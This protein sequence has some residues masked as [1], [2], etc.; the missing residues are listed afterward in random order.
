MESVSSRTSRTKKSSN[1]RLSALEKLQKLKSEGR[2]YKAE[3]KDIDNVYE[4]VD[5]SKYSEII[6]GR[7]ED[8]WIV[9]DGSGAYRD[10]GREIFEMEDEDMEENYENKKRKKTEINIVEK[11]KYGANIKQMFK[12]STKKGKNEIQDVKLQKDDI[13]QD[14]IKELDQTLM[15]PSHMKPASNNNF[16]YIPNREKSLRHNDNFYEFHMDSVDDGYDPYDE[17]QDQ[18]KRDGQIP[19]KSSVDKNDG[20]LDVNQDCKYLSHAKQKN[21]IAV[22]NHQVSQR[23]QDPPHHDPQEENSVS[24]FSEDFSND[25]W[26]VNNKQEGTHADT[27]PLQLND[28]RNISSTSVIKQGKNSG[29]I[30][31][32]NET[33]PEIGQLSNHPPGNYVYNKTTNK[34][35]QKMENGDCKENNGNPNVSCLKLPL[36]TEFQGEDLVDKRYFLIYWFDAYED[37]HNNP[38]TLY[39]FGKVYEKEIKEYVSCCV[40]VKNIPRTVYLLPVNDKVE[41]LD[42]YTEFNETT[43]E[44]FKI[45]KF[46]SRKVR[47][48]YAF[49]HSEQNDANVPFVSDYL[50]IKYDSQYPILPSYI[51]NGKYFKRILGTK[52]SCLEW[53]LLDKDIMG[54]SWLRIDVSE[55]AYLNIQNKRNN[56]FSTWCKLEFKIDNPDFIYTFTGSDQDS[57]K[58]TQIPAIPLL[59]T[60][61]LS[62]QTMYNPTKKQNELTMISGTLERGINLTFGDESD[63]SITNANHHL[64][65][66]EHFVMI[67]KPSD[68]IF[69]SD[70]KRVLADVLSKSHKQ[71]ASNDN[72]NDLKIPPGVK[73]DVMPSQ[74]ALISLFL[75]KLYRMDPDVLVGYDMLNMDLPLLLKA[76]QTF[77]IPNWSKIGRLKRTNI[78]KF[79]SGSADKHLACG[80][81]VCDALKNGKEHL[82]CDSYSLSDMCKALGLKFP[83]FLSH[84]GNLET[85]SRIVYNTFNSEECDDK[86][87]VPTLATNAIY[88]NPLS[89]IHSM[90][91][92]LTWTLTINDVCKNM[93]ALQLAYQLTVIAG[94]SLSRTLTMGR[95]ERNSYL[96]LHAF[97]RKGY[98]GPEPLDIFSNV[99]TRP[100]KETTSSRKRKTRTKNPG[101]S[102]SKEVSIKDISIMETVDSENELD[103][104]DV[105]KMLEDDDDPTFDETMLKA[106]K[107]PNKKNLSSYAGGLV[108]EPKTGFYDKYILLLDFNSLY[109]S[110]IQEYNVCF[111]TITPQTLT[112]NGD[113]IN[114]MTEDE[115]PI[116]NDDNNGSG[117]FSI[118]PALK[119]CLSEDSDNKSKESNKNI[120]GVL[121]IEI[122][123]LVERRRQIKKLISDLSRNSSNDTPAKSIRRALQL[124][125]YDIRQ[126]ALK[127]TANSIYGCL[128]FQKSRFYAKH[129]A[130]FITRK[131]R[132]ILGK[133]RTICNSLTFAQS[134][135]EIYSS[136]KGNEKS[137]SKS[138]TNFSYKIDVIY[139][140]TDSVMINTFL[141]GSD[142]SNLPRVMKLGGKIKTEINKLYKYLELDIDGVFKC[143][144]LIKKKKYAALKLKNLSLI[145]KIPASLDAEN[146][147]KSL[148]LYEKEVKGL[149]IVRRDWSF[150]AKKAGSYVLDQ[151]L[152]DKQREEII[153]SIHTYLM[154]LSKD[155]ESDKVPL[156]DY[157]IYKQ[158]NKNPEDYPDA[159][160]L[161]HVQVALRL[162]RK[163]GSNKRFKQGDTVGYVIC[164]EKSSKNFK[165]NS[166]SATQRAYHPSEL[167]KHNSLKNEIK[168]KTQDGH[169]TTL[170][171]QE[172][173]I[174]IGQSS[175]IIKH[176][177]QENQLKVENQS[178]PIATMNNPENGV[179]V[180]H[181]PCRPPELINHD[182]LKDEP[183]LENEIVAATSNIQEKGMKIEPQLES[184]IEYQKE[185]LH[186]EYDFGTVTNEDGKDFSDLEINYAMKQIEMMP[187]SEEEDP[188]SD[189][190]I[191]KAYYLSQQILPVIGRIC[192]FIEGTNTYI[193]EEC[194]GVAHKGSSHNSNNK[195]STDPSSTYDNRAK[196]QASLI[197]GLENFYNRNND[198]NERMLNI[199]KLEFICPGHYKLCQV[200]PKI[201]KH[202]INFHT[203]IMLDGKDSPSCSSSSNSSQYT[204][205][206][207]KCDVC[208]EE[209]TE[210]LPYLINQFTLKI[211]KHIDRYYK[212]YLRCE[213]ITCS[214]LT[215][216]MPLKINPHTSDC[217][218][219][220]CPKCNQ[221]VLV[222][223]YDE[224][225]LYDQLC[226]YENVLDLESAFRQYTPFEQ[227]KMRRVLQ[228]FIPYYKKMK[229]VVMR[230]L[231]QSSYAMIDLGKIFS[232]YQK[233]H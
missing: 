161:P 194:L 183:K 172:N 4:E 106:A 146:S 144:L 193:I 181:S 207:S 17:K 218:E 222:Q 100:E 101:K 48:K 83:Q 148:Y 29:N 36:K 129:L 203:I 109:P 221:A 22:N 166:M 151:I 65:K 178:V 72:R 77:K 204:C 124:R 228:P 191:D 6:R 197:F 162:N 64:N 50:E 74:R 79:H 195:G 145:P 213:D 81:L 116:V 104:F 216:I 121:P 226:Y 20:P 89:L 130:A 90:I 179:D 26:Y 150:L 132:E 28:I 96:L 10:D 105:S 80:R 149:D 94:N 47:K 52:T 3:I 18:Y 112:Q 210:F 117:P 217:N 119:E 39:I 164:L 127:L 87:D 45:K 113:G 220:Q 63:F 102:F 231:K 186:K 131:G 55:E 110:I 34:N 136:A 205:S 224:A 1:E 78:P 93:N 140:D 31:I 167:I 11:T 215:R 114:N 165:H 98:L 233:C 187:K 67:T 139:G 73:I 180:E 192:E 123:T 182:S 189:L 58:K 69:P 208:K 134:D 128:G 211:R 62:F 32:P 57:K 138:S 41:V 8:D 125:Q 9:D 160:S 143:L 188:K 202:T 43:A 84:D 91:D 12:A 51:P 7:Q 24:A 175:E 25:A 174:D 133:T 30:L 118:H 107:I 46:M 71:N 142:D 209:L 99:E 75:A 82:K 54:P 38:G 86:D 190:A 19:I 126:K 159:K 59:S 163:C 49:N 66:P 53:F 85:P 169:V 141:D 206:F 122:G 35:E 70:F 200:D 33:S 214:H 158:L 21:R 60:L 137:S 173:G 15:A 42:M 154:D 227:V 76:C 176:Y 23:H 225:R 201:Q 115:A 92:L 223:E 44:K 155:I 196:D 37:T 170:N 5:E 14:I 198:P 56:M 16:S 199:E 108:F 152:S 111:T 61:S 157:V 153:D 171:I 219:L 103:D 95:S 229:D 40:I 230:Y 13:L 88:S 2:K 156:H 212:N 147:A 27:K 68:S 120:L 168:L 185:T 184:D 232:F 97:H 177:S 135:L